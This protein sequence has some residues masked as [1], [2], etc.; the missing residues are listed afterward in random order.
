MSATDI[1]RDALFGNPPSPTAEPSRE[2]V[3][4]A[5]TDLKLRT[6]AGIAAAALSGTDL[7]AAMVLVAPLL[8][9]AQA[10]EASSAASAEAAMQ[11][12]GEV[13]GLA[14][15]IPGLVT[16]TVGSVINQAAAS[17][18][19]QATNEANAARDQTFTARMQAQAA[20]TAAANSA[21][22]IEGLDRFYPTRAAGE[23]ATPVGEPFTTLESGN[24]VY[25]LR[26]SG[27]STSFSPGAFAT[28]AGTQTISGK[29]FAGSQRTFTSGNRI[30]YTS[31]SAPMDTVRAF[32][33]FE[34]K[35]NGLTNGLL[36]TS[37]W[38]GTTAAPFQNNDTTLF[39]TYNKTLS[40]SDNYSW[41][42]S[43]PNAYHHI[44][45]GVRDGGIRHG[46]L[47]WA[48]SVAGKPGYVHSGT[49]ATQI[50]SWGRA[51]F[52][53][54]GT[55]S[56]AKVEYA[57]GVRGEIVNESVG[58]TITYS[59]AVEGF[60]S[61]TA[62]TIETAIGV[63]G[64]AANG[65]VANWS[66]LGAAGRLWNLQQGLFGPGAGPGPFSEMAS[67]LCS[68]E[69]GPAIEFGFPEAG[70]Y[71]SSIGA[72]PGSG[73][74]Y[75]GLNCEAEATGD[76]FRTRGRKGVVIYNDLNGGLVVARVPSA[77][78]TGQALA[79]SARF[80]ESG[81]LDLSFGLTVAG[82]TRLGSTIREAGSRLSLREPGNNIEF[83]HP[84]TGLGSTI[85]AT[86]SAGFSFLAL[87]AEADPTGNT[88]RTR[89]R[90]GTVVHNDLNGALIFSRVTTA[91]ASGQTLAES[92][93]LD[94]NGRLM[95]AQC[96]TYADNAAAVAGG[97]V[98][99]HVYKTATGELRIVV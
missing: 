56:S 61:A 51:G 5:F 44:P 93:R 98:A 92:A 23:A 86:N 74:S 43:A 68:R 14:A 11:A 50:G 75:I 41:S 16:T 89:G 95:L 28:L 33:H 26:T 55:P 30:G 46:V 69:T 76:G 96:P 62:G 22:S 66:Y 4:A 27:G 35:D 81:N 91:N 60:N 20:A 2:G 78:A 65:T 87:N 73:F 36:V 15:T 34:N 71:G 32:V 84:D 42:V 31:E 77:S 88:F 64:F 10:A 54:P 59:V 47:G 6:E 90:K 24:L 25:Y 1:L 80:D 8:S 17:A 3:V 97:L 45:L 53:G 39:E 19:V 21:S 9:S 48:T 7:D 94:A 29:T 40:N 49:L 12:Y 18:V 38:E 13:E 99:S 58:T 57:V 72:T 67:Y 83:G 82:V 63:Y 37:A 70:G 52:Q 79:T 85:G